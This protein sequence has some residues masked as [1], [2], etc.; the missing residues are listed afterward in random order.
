MKNKLNYHI[1][2][3]ICISIVNSFTL[4]AKSVVPS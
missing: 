3:L 1:L 2:L 4:L